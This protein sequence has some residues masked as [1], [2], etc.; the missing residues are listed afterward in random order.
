[1]TSRVAPPRPDRTLGLALVALLVL[2]ACTTTA[3]AARRTKRP[4]RRPAVTA[5]PAPAPPVVDDR[6]VAGVEGVS[7]PPE[8]E[9]MPEVD[10]WQE[11]RDLADRGQPDSALAVLRDAIPRSPEP[12]GLRWL[13]AGVTGETGRHADAVRLY[14]RLGEEF[15]EHSVDLRRDL[16]GER[17]AS[18]DPRGA[19]R[20][21]STWLEHHANDLDARR[22]LAR[23]WVE[24][25]SL[26]RAIAA[27]DEVLAVEPTDT[28]AALDRARILGWM[29]RHREAI[30]AYDRI[31]R[32]EPG[33]AEA[34]L[35]LARNLGWSG[36]NRGAARRLGSLVSRPDVEPVAWLALAWARYWDDDPDGA[37][38]ALA[39]Y[40][41][42]APGDREALSLANR[43]AREQRARV[44][45]GHGQSEDSDG[46]RV[47][48][49]SIEVSWPL[50]RATA[51]AGWRLDRTEDAGGS[52]AV[53]QFTASYRRRWSEVWSA[54]VQGAWNA[55]DSRL[56]TRP[57]GEAGVVARPT[58]R[59][60]VELAVSRE[61]VA[62]RLS[63]VEGVSLLTWVLAADAEPG[64][65]LALHADARAGSFSDGNRAER[66]GASARWSWRDDGRWTVA[67][68]V[69]VEQLNVHQ[70]LDHGYY[71]PDFYREGGPMAEFGWT[72]AP[73]WAFEATLQTGWQHEKGGTTEP[74]YGLT[75]ETRWQANDDWA[76]ELQ[77]GQGNSN[78]ASTSGYR[79]SWWRLAASRGF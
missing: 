36:D 5:K 19:A 8:P 44:E 29:G 67:T 25:D 66:T 50:P 79:R 64:P 28:D 17:L 3:D 77:A 78:L 16:A 58:E 39:R 21:L 10:P 57:G 51:A 2:A 48:S 23:A 62:T 55:W 15:P 54:H 14:E 4:V 69:R 73:R 34:E 30:T 11:A 60:R 13:E 53:R 41:T 26:P 59:T 61:A 31:L 74:F 35:G 12:F 24:A 72:P 49:P 43:I 42:Q 75:G 18:G 45:V 20:E 40:R 37:S 56:G 33:L 22:E 47:A 9:G 7:L 63:L 52:S 65:R 32:H 6:P 1:M 76:L 38:D 70:D 46:L 71:D 68:G 27:L